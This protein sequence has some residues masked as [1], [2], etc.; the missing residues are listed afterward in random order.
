MKYNNLIKAGVDKSD[1][2]A[3]VGYTLRMFQR[4]NS[5]YNKKW[6]VQ[7]HTRQRKSHI[8]HIEGEL[9]LFIREKMKE[10]RI[11]VNNSVVREKAKEQCTK[12]KGMPSKT[13]RNIITN[14]MR[15]ARSEL[16]IPPRKTMGALTKKKI[17]LG[18]CKK[19]N[20]VLECRR[21]NNC[22]HKRMIN[23]VFKNTNKIAWR[24]LGS[25]LSIQ[26]NCAKGDFII[27]Y[28]GKKVTANA[29][30]DHQGHQ[31]YYMRV[32]KMIIDG[33]KKNNMERF[34]NHFCDP[35]CA[36]EIK[37]DEGTLHACL[38][39][40]KKIRSGS[41]LTFDYNWQ[42]KQEDPS[43]ECLCGSKKCNGKIEKL[44]K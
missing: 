10:T 24:K 32:G 25:S 7:K 29:V 41:E 12:F 18:A 2:A 4:W 30:K 3:E 22:S 37:Y 19:D 15:R 26:E 28:F 44:M 9:L 13:Q 31:R 42:C 27:E 17:V 34:I 38:F 5:K 6:C 33:N 36:L 40:L 11:A 39:A 43:T 1:T 23:K 21:K 16:P 8:H 14:F 35:N 20:C